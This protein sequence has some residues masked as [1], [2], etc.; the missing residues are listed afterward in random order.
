MLNLIIV[1]L[2]NFERILLTLSKIELNKRRE[3]ELG[4]TRRD[5]EE[6]NLAHEA[7]ISSLRK[8]HA[9]T[10]PGVGNQPQNLKFIF[11]ILDF[12]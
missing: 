5:L 8:K 9:E 4:K 2:L 3:C 1:F 11:E 6:A 12:E 7:Q 10:S